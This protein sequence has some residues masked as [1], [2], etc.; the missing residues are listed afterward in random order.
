MRVPQPAYVERDSSPH[1]RWHVEALEVPGRGASA[2]PPLPRSGNGRNAL[3]VRGAQDN[4]LLLL[5][6]AE[7][8]DVRGVG[9]VPDSPHPRLA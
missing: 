8:V 5:V 1:Q 2:R 4:L 9:K 3:A 6:H 7:K